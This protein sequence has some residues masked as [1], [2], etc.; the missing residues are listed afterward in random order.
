MI[1]IAVR[2]PEGSLIFS[3][4]RLPVSVGRCSGECLIDQ[5]GVWDRHLVLSRDA[6]GWIIAIPHAE[7]AVFRDGQQLGASTRLKNEDRLDLGSTSLRFRISPA[8]QRTLRTL[9]TFTWC[10][11]VVL[12]VAQ[13]FLLMRF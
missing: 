13:I 4:D 11:L 5:T 3:L 1:E 9:E 6:E 12:V 2:D 7:A 10:G 8:R